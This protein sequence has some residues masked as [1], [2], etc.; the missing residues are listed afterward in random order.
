[1]ENEYKHE[2]GYE[3]YYPMLES[4][5][6][7]DETH[8]VTK[9]MQYSTICICILGLPGN[10][11]II[12]I[13]K[14]PPFSQMSHSIICVALALADIYYLIYL[15]VTTILE[16]IMGLDSYLKLC[17]IYFSLVYLG[18]HLDAWFVVFLT[19]ERLI[20][21]SWPLKAGQIMTKTR[22]IIVIILLA[23]LFVIWDSVFIFRYGVFEMQ[24]GNFTFEICDRINYIGVAEKFM[25]VHDIISEQLGTFVPIAFI[26]VG[27]I[28]II[29]KLYMQTKIR[30]QL[31]QGGGNELAKT[32]IMIITVTT[33]FVLLLAPSNIY[34]IV[35]KHNEDPNDPVLG[36]FY[37]LTTLNPAINCYLYFISGKLY[38]KQL[39]NFFVKVFCC[40]PAQADHQ[41]TNISILSTSDP[42]NSK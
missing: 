6:L 1:M 8:I 31:G 42:S 12:K 38:R 16:L 24:S 28:G 39:K 33:A 4:D 34:R 41:L 27:N 3:Y 7:Y 30:A 35:K 21:V 29:Y 36:L 22:I 26:F 13:M 23:V 20:A 25:V 37:I 32:N 14:E 9:I 19:Y 2:Y 5:G 40:N 15:F 18:Y 17:K 11:L 10:L